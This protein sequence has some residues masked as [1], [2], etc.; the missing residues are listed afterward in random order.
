[1]RRGILTGMA[2]TRTS[3]VSERSNKDLDFDEKLEPNKCLRD[4]NRNSAIET[5]FL[6]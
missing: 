6:P 1:M 2:L 4:I 3:G 5:L